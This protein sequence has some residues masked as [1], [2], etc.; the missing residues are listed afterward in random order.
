MTP[1]ARDIVLAAILGAALTAGGIAYL[2]W[3]ANP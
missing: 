3:A 1:N 2:Y